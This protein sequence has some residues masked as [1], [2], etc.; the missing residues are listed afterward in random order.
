MSGQPKGPLVGL[1]V[2]DFSIVIAGPMATTL[3]ADFGAEVVKVERPGVGDPLRMWAPFKDGQSL[4][5]KNHSRNKK[6]I[7]LNLAKPEGQAIAKELVGKADVAVESF[8]PGSMERWGLGYDALSAVNP[9]LVMLRM[10]GFGQ[11]GPYKERPGFGTVAEAMSGLAQ[12]TGFPDGPPILPAFPMAD[13]VAG[14]FGAMAIM[15]AI[16]H[17][18]RTGE[19]Q[20]IDASLYEPLFR[21]MIPNVPE[22][23]QLG[24]VRGRF[25]N[26]LADAAPRNLYQAKD[27]K[28]LSMSASTQG[29]WERVAVAIGR[30]GLI[31]DPRFIDNTTRVKN[32]VELNAYIQDWVGSLPLEEAM[33]KMRE[34][35]AVVGP[36]YDSAM[37]ASD[38]QYLEREDVVTIDD[39]DLGPLQ[40]HAPVPKLSKTPGA[41]HKAAPRL[42]EDNE[43][44]YGEWLGYDAKK[45]AQLKE[46]G[47]I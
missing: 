29:I 18:E 7:T 9:R 36:V 40:V 15:M 23:D 42:G 41:I 34:A 28:W 4:W 2:L 31:K 33:A 24:V 3:L 47:L 25:G 8:Q 6:S 22:Y 12:I 27:G 13:E 45:V 38:P 1:R 14:T 43:S 19:G 32:R 44:V 26:E 5:W 35:G 30:E 17:R 10:S 16:Y 20:W 11:T 39:P 46:Q 37:I 21:F